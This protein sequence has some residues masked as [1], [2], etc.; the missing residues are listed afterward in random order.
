MLGMR[1]LGG[2]YVT[3]SPCQHESPMN[4]GRLFCDDCGKLVDRA[5]LRSVRLAGAIGVRHS[6]SPSIEK[7]WATGDPSV[8]DRTL[9]R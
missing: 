9:A 7:F 2:L 3:V 6:T 1:P 5:G 4:V 8:F